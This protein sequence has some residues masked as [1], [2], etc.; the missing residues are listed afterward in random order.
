[1]QSSLVRS[2]TKSFIDKYTK[3]M[4]KDVYI[5]YDMNCSFMDSYLYLKDELENNKYLYQ[6][7]NDYKSLFRIYRRSDE[8]LRLHNEKYLKKN[9]DTYEDFFDGLYSKDIMDKNKRMMALM[10]EEKM[11][12]VIKD[13]IPFVVSKIKYMHDYSK[14]DAKKILILVGEDD[15]K[16]LKEELAVYE[17]EDV[18]VISFLDY[19]KSV[20]KKNESILDK[21]SLYKELFHYIIFNI[22]PD[23]ERFIKFYEAFSDSLYLN[24]DY[25]Y[26]DTF[27]DY[28][29]YMYKR[30][31]LESGLSLKK[32]NEREIKKRRRHLRTVNNIFVNSKEMVDVGNF[33]YLNSVD[34]KYD[35]DRECIVCNSNLTSNIISFSMENNDDKV[36]LLNNKRKYLEDLACELVKRQ[37]GMEKR[38]D[39]DI[40]LELFNTT[41][42]SYFNCLIND[43]FIPG[44]EYYKKEGNFE[45]TVFDK[46][47][48]LILEDIYNVYKEFLKKNN[49]VDEE[50]IH[51]R[52][53]DKI[54]SSLYEYVIL[55]DRSDIELKKKNF[56]ILKN[57]PELNLL[58]GNVRMFYD[59]KKYLS[60]NKKLA[61]PHV[62]LGFGELAGLTRMFL[63]ERL[64]SFNEMI[65]KN[66]ERI[67]LCF[68][69]EENKYR[70]VRNLARKVY[71][72]VLENK[73]KSI[74]FGFGDKNEIKSLLCD[75][76]FDKVGK[77]ILHCD[78][79]NISCYGVNKIDKKFD[80]I[81]LPSLIKNSYYHGIKVVNDLE[82]VKF[83]LFMSLVKAK[84]MVYLLCPNSRKDSY[85]KV[86]SYLSDV[87]CMF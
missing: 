22:Y 33:L 68:Y 37:Y 84:G 17:L 34:Y 20:L 63:R 82:V 74:A 60:E 3:F 6:D 47:Q 73:G 76:Y 40:Y 51:I 69:E 79:G 41:M 39:D 86:F 13:Y 27:H 61:V 54:E 67:C 10:S 4:T 55:V 8:V 28:H 53:K 24:Q 26:F 42:D 70:Y 38:S 77:D 15:L 87:C 80:V 14:I 12:Y 7:Q 23:K 85:L 35:A 65:E 83:G 50:D 72:I 44:I 75:G 43:I 11:I 45:G 71:D 36:I 2:D 58:K 18:S 32:Y 49:F 29:Y 66:Q 64:S 5:S 25:K 21:N 81:V 1:M 30:M 46:E 59:Y 9:I 48:I 56:I 62:Y 78:C 31:F 19:G 52:I 57:Y 16:H